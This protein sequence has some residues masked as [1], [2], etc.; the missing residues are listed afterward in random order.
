[1]RSCPQ[2]RF[3]LESDCSDG[4]LWMLAQKQLTI[5]QLSNC[6]AALLAL[7]P[8]AL[9]LNPP[10]SGARLAEAAAG[11][12]TLLPALPV[13]ALLAHFSNLQKIRMNFSNYQ[14]R[15]D[16]CPVPQTAR[17]LYYTS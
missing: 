8:T 9:Q 17:L 5:K 11:R 15:K 6:S 1:M 13:A 3:P 12:R 4:S 2:W 10:A 7:S 16:Y 14:L